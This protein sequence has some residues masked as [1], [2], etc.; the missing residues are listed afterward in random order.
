MTAYQFG[1][2]LGSIGSPLVIA[3]ALVWIW[4]KVRGTKVTWLKVVVVGLAIFVIAAIGRAQA[5]VGQQG[6]QISHPIAAP[7]AMMP[8]HAERVA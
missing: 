1:Y 8:A 3:F 5:P 7:A 2:L 6:V 4:T